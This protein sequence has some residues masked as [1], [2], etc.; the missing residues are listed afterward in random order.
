MNENK[1]I[2]KKKT[3]FS[4]IV[5]LL[6]TIL[7]FSLFLNFEDI[8]LVLE[9]IKHVDSKN[10]W[11][12]FLFLILY[13]LTWPI[14]LCIIGS[15]RKEYKKHFLD[16][17]LVGGAE[18]FF[19]GITPFATG[20]QPIQMYMLSKRKIN[21]GEATGVVLA[22]FIVILVASNIF[23]IISVFFYDKFSQ[24]FTPS[25]SW[26]I[27]FGFVMNLFTLFFIIMVSTFKFVRDFLR[28]IIL[29]LCKIK[30][31][32]K[33]LEKA[34]PIFDDYC[35]NAQTAVKEVFSHFWIFILAVITK[36]ISFAFYYAIPYFILKALGVNL[37][38]DM[39]W[40]SIL[41][42][43]FALT[44]MVWVPTPGGMGGIEFAFTTIFTVSIF[45]G[46]SHDLGVSGMILWR[47]L[48]YYLLLIISFITY[49]L[50]IFRV[51]YYNKKEKQ[52][53]EEKSN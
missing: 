29:L 24:N 36:L 38:I 5:V 26:M 37:S 45:G 13:F 53:I 19:N 20:G 4:V 27:I 10:M 33:H 3:I 15:T 25:T 32:G 30:F 11:L 17:Y 51:N 39:I 40:L 31:I 49:L 28:K 50:C 12:S 48:T 46:I 8:N 18:H 22:N 1:P 6:I 43:S 44:T 34:I 23:S 16:Y 52:L 9:N 14:S 41:A 2:S 21:S 7:V 42:S 35:L 47:G